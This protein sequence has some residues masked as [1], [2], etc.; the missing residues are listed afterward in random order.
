MVDS[1]FEDKVRISFIKAKEDIYR[2]ENEIKRLK[3]LL[4]FQQEQN[5]LLL[6]KIEEIKQNSHKEDQLKEEKKGSSTGNEG[7]C[8]H[9]QTHMQTPVHIP[10]H[11]NTREKDPNTAKFDSLSTVDKAFIDLT[12]KE[13]LIFLSIYQ[14]EDDL[15]KVTYE[16]IADHLKLTSGCIRTHVGHIIQKNM[17]VYREKIN[18]KLTILSI[19]KEFRDLNLKPRLINLYNNQD[20]F[21]KKLI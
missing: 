1:N 5:E 8:A 21:Q 15:G 3:E 14:L 13:F 7:V 4:I 18:N 16:D 19:T 2:L 11:I 10:V 17:P 9:M 6:N 12:K 20:P